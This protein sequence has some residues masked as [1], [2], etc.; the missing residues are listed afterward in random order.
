MTP[1]AIETWST[2]IG[3]VAA[4]TAMVLCWSASRIRVD[5]G[6]HPAS[7]DLDLICEARIAA[8]VE[9]GQRWRRLDALTLIAL[10]IGALAACAGATAAFMA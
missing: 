5:P 9:A 7:S 3:A 2:S 8:I 10:A 6:W 1:Y 4:I